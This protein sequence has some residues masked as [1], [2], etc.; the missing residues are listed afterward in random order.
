M[1]NPLLVALL[2]FTHTLSAQFILPDF[3]DSVPMSDGKKLPADVYIPAN[4]TSGPVILIQT[5]YNRQ[6]FR[7]SGLPL[8]IGNAIDSSH[9]AFVITDW[10]GFWGG[11]Q[12]EYSGAPGN[13]QDGYS[14]VEWIAAQS[15]SNGEVGTWGP[16]ALGNVQYLTA[17]EN[18][19]HLR[20]ICP[21]V[22]GPQTIYQEYYPNGC[23]RTEYLEQ[24]DA[25]GFGTSSW[26]LPFPFYSY[27]WSALAEPASFYPDSIFV[28][29][30][31]IGGWYD[32]NVEKMI[33]FFNAI[34]TQSPS[35]VRAEHRLLMGP[36]AHGGH[37]SAH[38]GTANQGE[39]SYPDAEGWSD[40]LALVFFDFHLRGIANGWD[41]SSAVRYFRM[42]ENTWQNS[43]TWPPSGFNPL[44]L[45]FHPD[46][47][48]DITIPTSSTASLSYTYDPNDPSPTVGGP[49]LRSDQLQGPYDQSDSVEVRNDVLKFTTDVLAQDLTL[50]GNAVVHLEISSNRYDTD[51][52]IRLCDV[53]PSGASM[54]VNDAAYRMRFLNG[55]APADTAALVPGNQYAVNIELPKTAITFL[56]GHRIRVDVSSSN[57][58]R[59]N[60]NMNT[61]GTMYPS[62]NPDTLVNPLIAT[63]T[64]YTNSLHSSGITLPATNWPNAVS[65][66]ESASTWNIW[67][68]P[69]QNILH[70]LITKNSNAQFNLRDVSGRL[71]LTVPLKEMN[72]DIF[73]DKLAAGIYMAEI[74]T[75]KG[76]FSKKVIIQNLN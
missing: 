17:K 72:T 53:Y 34:R 51:F 27:A 39:L 12:A 31:M 50:T 23:L 21:L 49:T 30:F 73:V 44:T 70:V 20:C 55:F 58:P 2:L 38:V 64:V 5:P 66:N 56:A 68:V 10:R 41:N 59:F 19:P 74:K 75:E 47:S 43:A 61:D 60:R 13:G 25:L 35:N 3:V 52:D 40:S 24:L 63:N 11:A 45:Y 42:G 76:I 8:G 14:I 57:Y 9:Y 16:S 7:L 46:Q 54:L 26:V 37:G 28:P 36:W 15:W 62:L 69:T 71:I 18:P 32:H 67:P 1:K 65:E 22:A 48:M 33:D 4:W 6:L 29:C